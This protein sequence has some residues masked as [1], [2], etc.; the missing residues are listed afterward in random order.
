MSLDHFDWRSEVKHWS[1]WSDLLFVVCQGMPNFNPFFAGLLACFRPLKW[2]PITT[3]DLEAAPG[4][5]NQIAIPPLVSTQTIPPGSQRYSEG[6]SNWCPHYILIHHLNTWWCKNSISTL[7]CFSGP[8]LG[9]TGCE[10]NYIAIGHEDSWWIF[11]Q[12]AREF[13]Q[14]LLMTKHA[15]CHSNR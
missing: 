13:S 9:L 7:R 6:Y 3:R 8:H 1:V 14:L 4:V 15:I 12:D 10:K 2:Q 11:H 5:A